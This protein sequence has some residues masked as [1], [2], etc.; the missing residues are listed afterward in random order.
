MENNQLAVLV[1]AVVGIFALIGLVK[2][3]ARTFRRNWLLAL[4][5]IVVLTPIWLIWA[6]IE[7]L[8][9]SQ[10]KGEPVAPAIDAL[11][12]ATKL[13]AELEMKEVRDRAERARSA[14][15]SSE[16]KQLIE[17]LQ[18]LDA[19]AVPT[20][21]SGPAVTSTTTASK[22]VQPA[23]VKPWDELS[24]SEKMQRRRED[25]KRN[26]P[27]LWG[28]LQLTMFVFVI[29]LSYF[30]WA[31]L[32]TRYTPEY[33]ACLQAHGDVASEAVKSECSLEIMHSLYF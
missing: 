23:R 8:T 26:H 30:G 10:A 29:F 16:N 7:A 19:I 18:L 27:F 28:L 1:A 9:G 4:F 6:I 31:L 21:V 33:T 17:Q 2:G 5:L 15:M 20:G 3:A 11:E 25:R 24:V 32:R 13:S 22:T 12:T 14:I